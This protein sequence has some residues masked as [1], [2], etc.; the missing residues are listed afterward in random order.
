[1]KLITFAVPSYNSQDYLE[2]C[3]D[4]LL[5]GGD[6]VEIIIVNDGS[7]DATARIADAYAEK[8]P[9]IVRAVHKP[10][11]GHGSGVNKGLEL[12]SGLYY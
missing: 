1:M 8:Y 5:T 2:K 10:N 9:E 3:I 11:G 7:T 6:E 4:S 12:A